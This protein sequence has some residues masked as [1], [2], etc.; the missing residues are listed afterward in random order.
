MSNID[1]VNALLTAIHFDR[2][3][4][5]EA[6]HNPDATFHSFRGPI[7]HDSVSIA[8]WHREFLR[9]YA[10]AQYTDIEYVESGDLVAARATLTAK[11][12]DW[13]AFSQRVVEVFRVVDQGIQERRLYAMLPDVELDKPAAQALAAALESRGDG[14]AGTKQVVEAFYTALLGRDSEAALAQLDP[15][16]TIIDSVVGIATGAEEFMRV[17]AETPSPAFGT[18]RVTN[19]IAGDRDALVELSVDGT[20]PRAADWVRVVDGKIRVVEAHWMLLEIGISLETYR[21]DRHQ[22]QVIMPI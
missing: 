12:Y 18:W 15:N 5:I 21:R 13:R 11:G 2:F 16:A 7:L 19:L 6:R 17:I 4:E 22:R 10:D 1:S 8:D 9:D 3:A 14:A 20:R